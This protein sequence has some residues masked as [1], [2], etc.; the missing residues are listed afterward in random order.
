MFYTRLVLAD[1][2]VELVHRRDEVPAAIKAERARVDSRHHAHEVLK[3]GPLQRKGGALLEVVL[4]TEIQ[5]LDARQ[6]RLV[7]R[8]R[9]V[10][11]GGE[12][13]GGHAANRKPKTENRK[14]KTT[15][16]VNDCLRVGKSAI[17]GCDRNK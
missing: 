9:E 13:R 11:R 10:V 1:G 6:H 5:I 12:H 4:E 16:A 8:L 2:V 3:R 15:R 17:R 14:P 7:L